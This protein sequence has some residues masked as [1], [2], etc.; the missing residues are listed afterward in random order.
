MA[1]KAFGMERP[2]GA[3]AVL[4]RQQQ[5]AAVGA[6]GTRAGDGEAVVEAAPRFPA[7]QRDLVGPLQGQFQLARVECIVVQ[8]VGAGEHH[9]VGLPRRKLLGHRQQRAQLQ[10]DVGQRMEAVLPGVTAA[11][12]P[13][14]QRGCPCRPVL[15]HAAELQVALVVLRL[16]RV[17]L[18][19]AGAEY[20]GLPP[21]VVE[22]PHL[23]GALQGREQA[24]LDRGEG[25][26]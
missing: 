1:E 5:P 22:H 24:T 26:G 7:G 8:Q 10:Q 3:V 12:E 15:E 9:H 25:D 16:L 14:Q 21:E 13:F 20:P 4:V 17:V 23:P 2:A 19:A 11:L 18:A 6:V